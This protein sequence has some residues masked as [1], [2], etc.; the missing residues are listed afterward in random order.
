MIVKIYFQTV[1]GKSIYIY[2]EGARKEINVA[3]Y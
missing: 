3:M 1:Q 2:T